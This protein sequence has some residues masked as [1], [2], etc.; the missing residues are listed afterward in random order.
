MSYMKW[1]KGLMD[2][3]RDSQLR[4]RYVEAKERHQRHLFFDGS[5]YDIEFVE[6]VLVFIDKNE[7]AHQS[8]KNEIL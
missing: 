2:T 4:T 5:I 1:V 3:G 7:D 6:S 8:T